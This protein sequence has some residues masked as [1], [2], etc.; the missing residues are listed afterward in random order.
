M[1]RIPRTKKPTQPTGITPTG[2]RV[3]LEV[4]APF[5][6]HITTVVTVSSATSD[7]MTAAEG[8]GV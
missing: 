5:P 2:N 6:L 8:Q 7:T 4:A 1:D 3:L